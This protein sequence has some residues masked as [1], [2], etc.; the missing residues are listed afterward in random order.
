MASINLPP[1]FGGVINKA[2]LAQALHVY[3]DRKHFGF[4]KTKRRGEITGSTRKI[5]RQK[6][7]GNARH[8]AKSAPIFVGGGK[9]HGPRGLKKT[10]NLSKKLRVKA[11]E[12]AFSLKVKE[13]KVFVVTNISSLE[14]TKDANTLLNK[15]IE[16]ENNVKKVDK[17]TI[18]LSEKNS[19]KS[20][21]LRNIDKAT[22]TSYKDL[23]AYSVYFGGAIVIDSEAVSPI[24]K[25]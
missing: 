9:A 18:L 24:E 7:T 6:G 25:K 11:L 17:F 4:S 21:F 20:K 16:K 10:L 13:K 2:L 15:I 1:R 14:K 8:G 5:Y 3:G 23:D 19:N 12:S 22:A